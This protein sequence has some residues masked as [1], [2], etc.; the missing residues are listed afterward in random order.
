[1]A[2]TLTTSDTIDGGAGTDTLSISDP[3][4]LVADLKVSNIE[5]VRIAATSATAYD[6]SFLSGYRSLDFRSDGNNAITSSNV[7]EGTSVVVSADNSNTITHGVLNA[8]NAGTT[9]AVTVTLDHSTDETDVDVGTL[10]LAGIETVT[11]VSSGVTS[12]NTQADLLAGTDTTA[13]T[14]G[15][16]TLTA[17]AM[18]TLN[19]SGSADLKVADVGGTMTALTAVS[20]ANLTGSLNFTN[21][22]SAT[23]ATTITGGSGADGITGRS[24]SDNISGGA[25]N[26]SLVGSGGND[27]IAGDAGNDT[28]TGGS[29]N[30]VLSGG[31]GNDS[32]TGGTGN[33]NL[34]GGAGNDTFV[35]DGADITAV[36]TANDTLAGGDNTDSLRFGTDTTLDLTDSAATASLSNVTGIE[37]LV[38]N[39]ASATLTINDNI[40]GIAGGTLAITNTTTAGVLAGTFDVNASG[41]LSSSSQVNTTVEA[42][43]AGVVTYTLG[44]AK[45]NLNLSNSSGANIVVAGTLGYFGANDTL[46][47]GSGT[48]DEL[49]FSHTTGQ[50]LTAAQLANVSGFE[51][52]FVTAA[53][54]N[55]SFTLTDDVLSRNYDSASGTPKLEIGHSAATNA[56]TMTV[57]GSAVSAT[58]ALSIT[59][60][61]GNDVLTG[62]AGNDFFVLGTGGVDAIDGGAGTRDLVDLSGLTFTGDD[63]VVVN[64]SAASVTLATAIDA[65]GF[66]ANAGARTGEQSASIAAGTFGILED[67]GAVAA[68]NTAISTIT[69]VERFTFGS[70]I[71]YFIGSSTAESVT[72][73]AGAD[74]LIAGGGNDTVSGG[75]GADQIYGGDGNDSLTG[76]A[77]AD[78]IV[79]GAGND[80]IN[81]GASAAAADTMTGGSGNDVFAF[82]TRAEAVGAMA[83]TDTTAVLMDRITDLIVGTDTIQLGT[84]A[85]AFGTGITFTAATV[86]N[87]NTV[88]TLG[89]QTYA[90]L[91]ALLAA[92]QTARTGVASTSATAQAYVVTTG[93][94][95]T[96]T[97]FSDKTLLIISDATTTINVSDTIIDITGVN[98]TTLTAGTFVFG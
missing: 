32:I 30:D 17:A 68:A 69:G 10:A 78:V 85:N 24:S 84:G 5:A 98:T 9:N 26:D 23:A 64:A 60:G 51:E 21:R 36:L 79:G 13:T 48:D 81:G 93:T 76:D 88:T 54:G 62:G 74:I 3:A 53:T 41:V 86:M 42:T 91:A 43:T 4:T 80:T 73:A 49:R 25:G 20:A 11:I 57:N 7:A 33:D 90:D 47:G 59:G 44:N 6:L 22:S 12:T 52:F 18:T 14:N 58:Y 95:T 67:N 50:T 56:G 8:A 37:R 96:A 87:I 1:M 77:D 71:D 66:G 45:D 97:G 2:A 38:V 55:Y 29:G 72:G 82:T 83:A 15:I 31:D 16:A 34:S 27:T 65:G 61:A 75:D 19:I 89:N 63:G 70:G 46:V 39:V 40:V 92:V 94:I 28:I 35:I